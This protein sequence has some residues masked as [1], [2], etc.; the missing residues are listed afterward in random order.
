MDMKDQLVGLNCLKK[1]KKYIK[2]IL[3]SQWLKYRKKDQ[4]VI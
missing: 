4:K 2:V 3:N 1:W